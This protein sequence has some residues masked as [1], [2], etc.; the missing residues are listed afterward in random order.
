MS[1]G[2]VTTI[3]TF[4]GQPV[5]L[6]RVQPASYCLVSPTSLDRPRAGLNPK[7]MWHIWQRSWTLSWWWIHPVHWGHRSL[8]TSSASQ[9]WVAT[10]PSNITIL[11]KTYFEIVETSCWPTSR[12][13]GARSSARPVSGWLTDWQP[14]RTGWTICTSPCENKLGGFKMMWTL[15]SEILRCSQVMLQDLTT[16]LQGRPEE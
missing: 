12:E 8:P 1:C 14:L 7:L 6:M 9:T 10:L 2:H 13:T 11:G 4:A 5:A 15:S 16:K 3:G